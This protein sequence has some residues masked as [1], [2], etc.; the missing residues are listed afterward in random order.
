LVLRIQFENFGVFNDAFLIFT[1]RRVQAG[2]QEMIVDALGSVR[3]AISASLQLFEISF[4]EVKGCQAKMQEGVA[5]VGS[6]S[7]FKF[8]NASSN[9]PC[10][11]QLAL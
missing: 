10:Q 2:K 5:G 8:F 1:E 4:S 6:G 3:A 7:S 9:S 11:Q